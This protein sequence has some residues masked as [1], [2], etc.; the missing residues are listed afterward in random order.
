MPYSPEIYQSAAL[1]LEKR[2]DEAER[3][4]AAHREE[5]YAAVPEIKAVDEKLSKEISDISVKMLQKDADANSVITEIRLRCDLMK[6]EHA[7]LL[8]KNGYPKNYF[9]PEYV[10]KYCDDTGRHDGNLC[11]CYRSI[12]RS[13]A[14]KEL[15]ESSGAAACSF[16]NFSLDYYEDCE[17]ADAP[18]PRKMMTGIYNSCRN[19]AEN[20]SKDSCSILM[21][22][23]TGLGKTH[24]SLAIAKT[25]IEHDFG[26]VYIPAQRLCSNLEL[27]H[28][29]KS[30]GDGTYRKYLE[31]DLLIIDDLGAEFQSTFSAACLY[32]VINS[33]INK[34]KPFI[35][36][37]NFS[38]SEIEE[39]YDA[40]LS[41]RI[42]YETLNIPFPKVDIR[43]EKKR[44]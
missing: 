25:V 6:E 31:C 19:Y 28:F 21:M 9:E 44:K 5:V 33:R 43:L 22:G 7:E 23:K 20:F 12:C 35:I 15:E 10:C 42:V 41:S 13:L 30:G 4:A 34:K 2:R 38:L 17:S 29:S 39:I 18:S 37:T 27:E 11:E 40:R 1:V 26:V 8:C 36:S 32:H 24:L 14:L 3:I 16:D